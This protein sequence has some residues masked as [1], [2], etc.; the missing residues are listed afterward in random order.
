[1][2]TMEQPINARS[3]Q[4]LANKIKVNIDNGFLKNM[5]NNKKRKPYPSNRIPVSLM[6]TPA[7]NKPTSP[8]LKYKVSS[9]NPVMLS[10]NFSNK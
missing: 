10:V 2:N 1:M 7:K 9:E 6:Q 3:S 8:I 4:K 5:A